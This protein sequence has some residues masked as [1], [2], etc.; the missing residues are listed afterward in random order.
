MSQDFVF[1]NSQKKADLKVKSDNVAE[2]WEATQARANEAKKTPEFIDDDGE[3]KGIHELNSSYTL[4]N[5]CSLV[6]EIK[7]CS[8]KAISDLTKVIA[9]EIA[10]KVSEVTTGQ[11]KE[12]EFIKWIKKEIDIL[13]PTLKT[14]NWMER[15]KDKA[16]IKRAI[17]KVANALKLRRLTRVTGRRMKRLNTLRN[18][19]KISQKEKN[20]GMKWTR[21]VYK[22]STPDMRDTRAAQIESND[23]FL[24]SKIIVDLKNGNEFKLDG[25]EEQVKK[26]FNEYYMQ[27]KAMELMSEQ[28]GKRWM[29]ITMTCPPRMHPN[30][31]K[32][33][34]SYDGT[35][36]KEAVHFINERWDESKK[37]FNRSGIEL[38]K[39]DAYGFRIIEPHMDGCPHLHVLLFVNEKDIRAIME[40]VFKGFDYKNQ[41]T[42]DRVRV[43][44][45]LKKMDK[46]ESE[47]MDGQYK[48]STPSVTITV[49]QKVDVQIGDEIRPRATA[50]TY[51]SKYLM[52]CFGSGLDSKLKKDIAS[53]DAWRSCV[54]ARAFS[55]IGFKG[56]ISK[57]R[58]AKM[59]SGIDILKMEGIQ[60][61]VHLLAKGGV[62]IKIQG[63]WHLWNL[64]MDK[65]IISYNDSE[66]MIKATEQAHESYLKFTNLIK[67]EENSVNIIKEEYKNKYGE[68]K[69][70]AVGLEVNGLG[71]AAVKYQISDQK[72]AGESPKRGGLIIYCPSAQPSACAKSQ[73]ESKKTT[74]LIDIWNPERNDE[75]EWT[76][77]EV[78]VIE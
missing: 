78:E 29:F 22:Y 39:G 62:V 60:K 47:L 59:V 57:W 53:V 26:K 49:D 2:L 24:K 56:I 27:I 30:P 21:E 66:V 40:Y 32:G 13:E 6:L 35:T 25:Y 31:T 72:I 14:E 71:S 65:A 45:Y 51:V 12:Q 67:E 77:R 16:H 11:A 38:S 3:K 43:T 10:L 44:G 41:F 68:I 75:K 28:E 54:G 18:K 9:T 4:S 76:T 74:K 17:T 23:K 64:K 33:K 42:K 63:K 8:H 61:E 1:V 46:L 58:Q 15:I 19:G 70:R 34:N 55:V 69:E 36:I 37:H 20:K 7:N 52:K 73:V 48:A 5:W 50:A